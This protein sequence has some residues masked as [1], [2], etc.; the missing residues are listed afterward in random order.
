MNYETHIYDWVFHYNIYTSK[1]NAV[2]RENYHQLFNGGKDV[3]SSS[4]IDTLITII[5]RTDGDGK[6]LKKLVN[7]K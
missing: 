3:L 4:E 7:G 1:W 6:K 5:N 2:R